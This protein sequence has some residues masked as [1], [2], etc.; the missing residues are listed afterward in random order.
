MAN[1]RF[2]LVRG[3]RLRATRL[4]TCG[5]IADRACSAIVTKGFV[6]VAMTANV[7]EGEEITVQNASGENCVRDPA[8]AQFLGY[9]VQITFCDVDPELYSMLTNQTVVYD[10]AGDA[11]GFRVN[12]KRKVSDANFALE[13]WSG[14]PGVACE[15][16]NAA[17]SFGY[18]LLP[19]VSG[20]VLGDFTLENG[21]VS[22]V[23]QNAQTKDGANWGAGPYNV[24]SDGTNAA[25]LL[26]PLDAY[27]HLH[28]QYTT[29]APPE[30]GAECIPSGPAATGATAGI[31][32][33]LT[34]ADSYPPETYAEL[35]TTH[36]LTASPASAWTTG[37]HVV[38]GDSSHAYW[39]GTDWQVG[40]AP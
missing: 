25:P 24:V 23:L 37:Q 28:V 29:I 8:E 20:G 6:S 2:P 31:P 5:R 4:D 9:G 13:L 3:R 12:S 14:V 34:P 35:T 33:T 1:K 38:L 30:P 16:P 40:E 18:F 15:D 27:D 32:A 26:E 19:F 11:V 36:T 7:D 17:G 22:F 10:S 39:D 21:A